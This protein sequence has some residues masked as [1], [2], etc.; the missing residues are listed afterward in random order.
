M[1]SFIPSFF[2]AMLA[3]ILIINFREDNPLTIWYS[4]E[5]IGIDCGSGFSAKQNACLEKGRLAC[6]RLDDMKEFYS[7]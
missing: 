2:G 5:A 7:E 6:L 1:S 3:V 4:E